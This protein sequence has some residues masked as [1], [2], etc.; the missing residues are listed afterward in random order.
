M[1]FLTRRKLRAD[2]ARC[3]RVHVG[4]GSPGRHARSTVL[5]RSMMLD[6]GTPHRRI[7]RCWLVLT[8]VT[9]GNLSNLGLPTLLSLPSIA[10]SPPSPLR[11]IRILPSYPL[12]AKATLGG[13][14]YVAK[15]SRLQSKICVVP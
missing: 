9:Q 4:F 11:L 1:L 6:C 14:L 3:V 5:V 15:A 7:R 10:A 13:V 8:D 2:D 12:K